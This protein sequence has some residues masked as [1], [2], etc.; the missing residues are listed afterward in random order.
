MSSR[1]KGRPRRRRKTGRRVEVQTFAGTFS[2]RQR[3]GGW[4]ELSS[5]EIDPRLPPDQALQ[6]SRC[7]HKGEVL[8]KP[9]EGRYRGCSERQ[10]AQQVAEAEARLAELGA[11]AKVT[12]RESPLWLQLEFLENVIGFELDPP[13]GCEH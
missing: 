4:L 8:F 7:P 11:G 2:G 6:A 12:T 10:L 9:I 3:G 5:Y 13:C 1:L